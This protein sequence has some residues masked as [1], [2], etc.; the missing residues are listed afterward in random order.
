MQFVGP[1]LTTVAL[2]GGIDWC[3]AA[4]LGVVL[5]PTDAALGQA[6]V[7]DDRILVRIRALNIESG[8]NDG[9]AAPVFAVL[10]A[11]AAGSAGTGEPGRSQ[12]GHERTGPEI[13]PNQ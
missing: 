3:L 11:A 12:M 1:A 8:L 7:T 13:R 6:V 5:A 10:L 4:L 2:F 9:L